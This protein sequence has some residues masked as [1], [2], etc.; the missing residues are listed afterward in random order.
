[1]DSYAASLNNELKKATRG[2]LF[3]SESDYPVEPFSMPATDGKA[4]SAADIIAAKKLPADSPVKE[5]KLDDFFAVAVQEQE[6]QGKEERERAGR[7]QKLV[8]LLKKNLTDIRVYR[9]GDVEADVY[10]VGKGP[11][12]EFA[13]VTTKVVE[14]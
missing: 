3:Q 14:S 9:I 4:L 5:L 2:L 12:G 8:A 13:G 7:F 1:M 11:S 10:V 6:W